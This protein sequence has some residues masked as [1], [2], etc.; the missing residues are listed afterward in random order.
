[1]QNK[2]Q[3]NIQTVTYIDEKVLS[4]QDEAGSSLGVSKANLA[5]ASEG[6]GPEGLRPDGLKKGVIGKPKVYDL[7]GN[8]IAEEENL[9]VLRGREYLA[10]ILSGVIPAGADPV[11]SC[12]NN[13][14]INNTPSPCNYS[15]YKITHFAVGDE[16]TNGDCPPVTQGPYDD[17][18]NV[19][20]PKE[21]VPQGTSAVQGLDYLT[22]EGPQGNVNNALKRIQFDGSIEVVQEE[23]TINTL[24]GGQIPVQ[25]Y[26]AIKFQMYLQPGE[27]TNDPTGGPTNTP[28]DF[29]EAGLYAVEYDSTG[30]PVFT[31]PGD[32]S[33]PVKALLFARF[34]TLDK[35]LEESDGIMIEWY[36]LV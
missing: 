34:T 29:N 9:V 23:H 10:Q 28:F 16:G 4:P 8:L 32:P 21:L 19:Y 35:Y 11:L 15:N 20:N 22:L 14:P 26:T 36:V 12:P 33:S 5:V 18:I 13:I 7:K 6:I 3:N 25:A 1:M 30:N 17:D 24:T 2:P 27:A 31:T